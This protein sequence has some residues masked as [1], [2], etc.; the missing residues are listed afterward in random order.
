VSG[1]GSGCLAGRRERR[2]EVERRQI[3]RRRG[4][5]GCLDQISQLVGV[6]YWERYLML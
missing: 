4:S 5:I 1:A 6:A 2:Q 3:G